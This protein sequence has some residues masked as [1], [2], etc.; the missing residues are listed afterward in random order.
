MK[1]FR[2]FLPCHRSIPHIQ[3]NAIIYPRFLY[4]RYIT[5]PFRKAS[6]WCT[7]LERDRVH[8]LADES[9]PVPENYFLALDAV[10]TAID[11]MSGK[12]YNIISPRTSSNPSI[13]IIFRIYCNSSSGQNKRGPV[14]AEIVGLNSLL[15]YIMERKIGKKDSEVAA[16]IW[17]ALNGIYKEISLK[18]HT[19]ISLDDAKTFFM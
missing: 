4:D 19:I 5:A 17:G 18:D 2:L 15:L 12:P 1:L 11:M 8:N 10:K 6:L 3:F 14:S 7:Y 9:M 16:R 13:L